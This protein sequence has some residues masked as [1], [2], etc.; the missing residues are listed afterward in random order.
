[1]KTVAA[2]V[3]LFI[4][5][6]YVGMDPCRGRAHFLSSEGGR[7]N[8]KLAVSPG[9]QERRVTH[10]SWLVQ[11]TRDFPTPPPPQRL[12]VVYRGLGN[13]PRQ[14]SQRSCATVRNDL[15]VVDR[16][17]VEREGC[18][19][20]GF[21]RYPRC[22]LALDRSLNEFKNLEKFRGRSVFF[23]AN[24]WSRYNLCPTR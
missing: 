3:K 14:F 8:T 16:L 9:T 17:D 21:Y 5:S 18:G 20:G 4:A 11:I 2:L 12:A 6:E 22:D 23:G 19:R 15:G 10:V 13:D 24:A 1:M 7:V